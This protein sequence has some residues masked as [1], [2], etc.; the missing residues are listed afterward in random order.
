MTFSVVTTIGPLSHLPSRLVGHAEVNLEATGPE[1]AFE[2][3][4]RRRFSPRSSFPH[5][6]FWLGSQDSLLRLLLLSAWL[7][8]NAVALGQENPSTDR[9]HGTVTTIALHGF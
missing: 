6:D 9:T 4:K 1:T 3:R 8:G 2:E 5:R 7:I